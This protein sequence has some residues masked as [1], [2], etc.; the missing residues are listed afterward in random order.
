MRKLLV[1][2][3]L[4]LIVAVMGVGGYY[5]YSIYHFTQQIQQPFKQASA[6]SSQ[7]DGSSGAAGEDNVASSYKPPEWEGKERVNILVMGADGR[8]DES[9]R[10]DSMMVLSVDPVKKQGYL[11]SVLRD[12]YTE[13]PGYRSSRINTAFS[14][15]GPELQ[16]ETTSKLLGIPIQFY[17][18][19]NFDG[20]M[21]LVDQLGGIDIDV[22]KDMKYEDGG[23]HHVYD[24]DL[25]KGYQHLDG[26]SALQY[27]RFRHD[28]TSDFTRTERQRKFLKAVM[29]EV[30][31][32]SSLFKMPSLLNSIAPY[33]RTNM[34]TEDML[35]LGTLAFKIPSSRI[36]GE[37]IPPN[38]LVKA[39][40]IQGASVLT[41]DK[42]KLQAYVQ[43]LF[44][45]D[46][47]QTSEKNADKADKADNSGSQDGR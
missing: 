46:L 47:S 34:S 10:S 37:Q 33:I 18:Y 30:Q 23:D 43:E 40:T 35:K 31:S 42:K 36:Q 38:S 17:L 20:F 14:V 45:A 25:K 21:E 26:K 29:N 2:I 5:L 19:T 32:T 44:E 24:I 4:A 22:E 16:M 7:N 11:M 41:V 8:N 28:A 27:V 6:D 39:E 13:I 15:G 1:K 12:T 9:G 3:S